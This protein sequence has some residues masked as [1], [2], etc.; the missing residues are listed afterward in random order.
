MLNKKQNYVLISFLSLAFGISIALI[1]YKI[2]SVLE[3]LISYFQ[4]DAIIASWFMSALTFISLVL[5]IPTSLFIKKFGAKTMAF[6]GAIFA[7]V[8]SIIGAVSPFLPSSIWIF[9]FSRGLEGFSYIFVSVSMPILLSIVVSQ[10]KIG[11][12]TGL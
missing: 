12:A 1:I 5:A 11:F 3:Y 9:V 6:V 10:N 8:G 2:P 7:T 4:T